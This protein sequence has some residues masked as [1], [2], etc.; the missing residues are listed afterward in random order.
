MSMHR[1]RL[2]AAAGAAMLATY[3]MGQG[4]S[5]PT[6]AASVPVRQPP[7]KPAPWPTPPKPGTWTAGPG[8]FTVELEQYRKM[9]ELKRGEAEAMRRS[10]GMPYGD[11]QSELKQYERGIKDYRDL[12]DHARKASQGT[13]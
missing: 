6:L 11:Y 1:A 7:I 13:P 2:A 10:G 3:A 8:K 5:A 9:L 4:A 12:A